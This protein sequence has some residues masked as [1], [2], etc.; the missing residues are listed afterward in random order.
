MKRLAVL[1]AGILL[2]AAALADGKAETLAADP[3]RSYLLE[4]EVSA[5][6]TLHGAGWVLVA[7]FPRGE[8]LAGGG[9]KRERTLRA[10]R[11]W[12]H[13]GP[14]VGVAFS[15]PAGPPVPPAY[16]D[17]VTYDVRDLSVRFIPIDDPRKG[18]LAVSVSPFSA[19][20][21]TY[22]IQSPAGAERPIPLSI[23]SPLP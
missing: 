15:V 4:T 7:R 9:V 13:V 20:G 19:N 5:T 16:L 10:E 6:L 3:G 22:A 23:R 18:G 14:H 11:A 17:H 12:F 2:A 8:L 21:K 1:L